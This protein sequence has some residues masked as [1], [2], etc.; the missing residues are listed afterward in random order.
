MKTPKT[1]IVTDDTALGG[2]LEHAKRPAVAKSLNSPSIFGHGT[3]EQLSTTTPVVAERQLDSSWRPRVNVFLSKLTHTVRDYGSNSDCPS[4]TW[5]P[6]SGTSGYGSA[7]NRF[8]NRHVRSS[9]Q[10]LKK[11]MSVAQYSGAWRRPVV[12]LS[13]AIIVP[14]GTRSVRRMTAL[15]RTDPLH[16][17][18]LHYAPEAGEGVDR[19][20][21]TGIP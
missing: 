15:F 5:T 12:S 8:A 1:G 4:I 2:W 7:R 14:G 10:V 3:S 21:L 6:C 16:S 20:G 11:S 17:A 9:L 18:G 19:V 13:S